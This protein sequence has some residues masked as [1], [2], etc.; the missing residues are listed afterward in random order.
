[1]HGLLLVVHL[2]AASVW[3]GHKAA[4]PGD[5]RQSLAAGL[6]TATGMVE[7]LGRLARVGIGAALLTVASGVGL[8]WDAGWTASAV[9][10]VG[11]MCALGAMAVGA[12]F[13]RPAW[14]GL[15]TAVAD[16]D[17]AV[18][19]AYGRRFSRWLTV[20]SALWIAALWAMVA[21]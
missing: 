21:G 1:M 9:R 8:L 6:A 3:F 17:L 12:A 16:E 10:G 14:N 13:A 19:G 4:V 2:A 15:A 11:I 18:A 20:E 7:R 5:I